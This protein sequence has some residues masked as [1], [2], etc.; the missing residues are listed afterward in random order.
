MKSKKILNDK[1]IEIEREK[2]FL[3]FA[4]VYLSE[5]QVITILKDIENLEKIIK[6]LIS[7]LELEVKESYVG[8][9]KIYQLKAFNTDKAIRLFSNEYELLKTIF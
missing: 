5:P 8:V 7:K 3:M 1:M 4:Y 2:K 6:L 9:K